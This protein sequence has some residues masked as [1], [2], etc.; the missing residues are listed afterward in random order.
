RSAVP[1]ITPRNKGNSDARARALHAA[2]SGMFGWLQNQRKVTSNPC[3]S[4]RPPE[5]GPARDRTL[6]AHELRWLWIACDSLPLAYAAAVKLLALTG[7][8]LN[9][10]CGLRRDEVIEDRA[11]WSLP[12]TRTKNHRPHKVPLAPLAREIIASLPQSEGPYLLS[13]NGGLSG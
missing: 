2:I 9:E 7:G 8:R 6:S 10:V 5:Q 13:T 4:V 3:A 12:E 11:T 1:G